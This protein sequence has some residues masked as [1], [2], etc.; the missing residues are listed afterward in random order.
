MRVTALMF[1]LRAMSYKGVIVHHVNPHMSE[2]SRSRDYH[3][4]CSNSCDRFSTP[5][6]TPSPLHSRQSVAALIQ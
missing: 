6:G 2:G 3:K 1:D 4:L 5:G